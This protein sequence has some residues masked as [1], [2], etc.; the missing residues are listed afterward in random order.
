MA[1]QEQRKIEWPKY[2]FDYEERAD[3]WYNKLGEKIRNLGRNIGAVFIAPSLSLQKTIY[4]YLYD[5]DEE[6]N[7][8]DIS[9]LE[10]LKSQ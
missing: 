8:V 3:R 6:L 10:K 5:E 7:D 4:P 9:D 2:D 1:E